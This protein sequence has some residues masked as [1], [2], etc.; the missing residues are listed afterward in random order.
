MKLTEI[1][2]MWEED[3]RIDET[4]LGRESTKVPT[5]HAKYITLISKARLQ[6][7]KAE[8]DYYNTRRLK[9][10]YYRGEMTREELAVM[11]WEQFQGN[12]PLKNEM[13]EFLQCD[14]DLIELQDK[15]EYF[16]T[17]IYTLEQIIRSINS[18]TWD[19]KTAVEWHKFTNGM[20]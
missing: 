15:M 7:R 4:N 17:V 18:R 11:E 1:Q 14:K 9:Y 16:K 5:L 19:I 13:D 6:L 20:M 3:S 8:S 10:R 12:K 2:E